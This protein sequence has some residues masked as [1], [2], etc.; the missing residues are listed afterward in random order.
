MRHLLLCCVTLTFVA[1]QAA[2]WRGEKPGGDR[3]AGVPGAELGVHDLAGGVAWD[4]PVGVHVRGH[5]LPPEAES[6]GSGVAAASATGPAGG[7]R[8]PCGQQPKT[9]QET[10]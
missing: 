4:E 10:M 3:G 2:G 8:A 6:S 7:V 1:E 5:Q 9:T